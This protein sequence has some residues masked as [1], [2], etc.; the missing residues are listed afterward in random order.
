MERK[1][2]IILI[3]SL[4]VLCIIVWTTGILGAI[5]NDKKANNI[6][7]E[8]I[9]QFQNIVDIQLT[10]NDKLEI[11]N[12]NIQEIQ[13][14][15]MTIEQRTRKLENVE[16]NDDV[17]I[18][19][20][21]I[22]DVSKRFEYIEELW[23]KLNL[24]KFTAT[25]YSPFDNVS[26]IE[27]D[28]EP[29]CTATGTYPD[30]GTIAVDPAIIPYYSNMIIIGEDFIEHGIALDTGGTMR[31]YNYWI[32]LYRDTYKQTLDFGKQDVLVIWK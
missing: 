22:N 32:D 2:R 25:A 23:N 27:N 16:K 12:T 30:W 11:V 8:L 20:E 10:L 7:N 9:E 31:K 4:I 26:G 18:L 15:I 24:D 5:E 28:G 14:N 17:A 1:L 13:A 29:E 6:Q 19:Q 21:S 3:V